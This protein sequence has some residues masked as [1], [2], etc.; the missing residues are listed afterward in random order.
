MKRKELYIAV[1]CAAFGGMTAVGA[2]DSTKKANP[3]VNA[4]Q[5]MEQYELIAEVPLGDIAGAPRSEIAPEIANPV[6][7]DP[8]AIKR[9]E[10]LFKTMNCASCHAYGGT[11]AMGPD[12]TDTFWLYGGTPVM[13]YKSIYEGRPEGMPA[14][15]TMLPENP[16]W[17]ITAYI[18]SLGGSFPA[19][20]FAAAMQGDLGVGTT[21]H[22]EKGATPDTR[23]RR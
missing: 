2:A 6:S 17:D 16:I 12:L 7:G 1:V 15:K 4:G 10:S 9:G 21:R 3:A 14:W 22:A 13:I 11:G 23:G 19:D 8:E 20:K 5:P 18:E